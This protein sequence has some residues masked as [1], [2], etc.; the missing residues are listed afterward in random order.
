MLCPMYIVQGVDT[1]VFW[2]ASLFIPNEPL[3][4]VPILL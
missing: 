3:T 4:F 1:V 2:S